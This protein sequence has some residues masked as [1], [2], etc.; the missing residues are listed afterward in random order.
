[1]ASSGRLIAIFVSCL[2]GNDSFE[3]YKACITVEIMLQCSRGAGEFS[4]IPE[5]RLHFEIRIV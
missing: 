1:M 3:S 4:K 2:D 5:R